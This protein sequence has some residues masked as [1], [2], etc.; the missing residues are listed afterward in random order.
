[1]QLRVFTIPVFGGEY[2]NEE[3]N[4]FMRANRIISVDKPLVVRG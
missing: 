4:K 1:M 2:V 3:M